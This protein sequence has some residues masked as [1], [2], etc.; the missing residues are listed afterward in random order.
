MGAKKILILEDDS[1]LANALAGTVKKAGYESVICSHPD[2]ALNELDKNS[3]KLV[4]IDCLL[5]Q[6]PGVDVAKS[7]RKNFDSEILPIVMM[8][9]IF[10]DKQMMKD[11]TNEIS[12]LDFLKKPFEVTEVLKF[13]EKESVASHDERLAKSLFSLPDRLG[14]MPAKRNEILRALSKIHGFEL[15]ILL[16]S[17]VANSCSGVIQL[18]DE[19]GE[20]NRISFYKGNIVGV[21][22]AD[23]QSTLGKLLIANGW[24]LP[25][26]LEIELNRPS[27]KK[28]G[29][30]LV[31]ENLISPH[32]VFD[33]ME[34]QMALRLEKM[35]KDKN[36]QIKYEET[37]LESNDS[38]SIDA[39]E[40]Y[41]LLDHWIANLVASEWLNHQI[42]LW[43]GYS[44]EFG[45]NHDP[46]RHDYEASTIRAVE[47]IIGSIECRKE[48]SILQKFYY[49]RISEFNKAFYFM[50]CLRFVLF[51][52]KANIMSEQ[53]KLARVQK[54]WPQ[55]KDANLIE[56]FLQI[57]G[58]R[59]MTPE[60]VQVVYQDFMKKFP[61]SLGDPNN[62]SPQEALCRTVKERVTSAY[63][64]FLEP[65]K[66]LTYEREQETGHASKRSQALIKMEEAK[67]FLSLGQYST[68]TI[69]IN[70]AIDL[71]P[72]I[73]SGILY[74]VWVKVGSLP[75]NKNVEKDLLLDVDQMLAKVSSEEMNSA[76]GCLVQGLV[77][78]RKRDFVG[79][80]AFFERALATDKSLIEARRELN[81]LPA[82]V[83]KP[84]DLLHGDLSVVL[85]SFFKKS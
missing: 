55:I 50:L 42:N 11:I 71:Y 15:P 81:K 59:D 36:Y 39:T 10:T 3:F 62:A 45:P 64:L 41:L 38:A 77:A 25:S 30:R 34:K 56:T 33:V 66:V 84:I 78:K 52:E 53:E 68:A 85:G 1:T 83:K 47:S 20:V 75:Q 80:R 58:R 74:R 14:A 13:L 79:A 21:D 17:M 69:I 23:K 76:I 16:T 60:E 35:I 51:T 49:D 29:Q 28:I 44:V 46:Y 43:S 31:E 82:D 40:Y 73:D 61:T 48:L 4:F 8:S 63:Q 7:I 54:L 9:G 57:G 26:D 19:K 22:S 12:A 5:P 6:T 18:S 65:S 24:V 27:E 67:K 2:E 70:K 32:A 37:I 72:G